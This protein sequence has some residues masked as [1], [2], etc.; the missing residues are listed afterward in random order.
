M[1]GTWCSNLHQRH[2]CYRP[3]RFL[4]KFK[5]NHYLHLKPPYCYVFVSHLATVGLFASL[6]RCLGSL[7]CMNLWPSGKCFLTKGSI[8]TLLYNFNKQWCIHVSFKDDNLG[9]TL[10]AYASPNVDFYRMFSSKSKAVIHSY[11]LCNSH[12]LAYITSTIME[13]S[14]YPS[15]D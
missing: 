15:N 3:N 14:T 7:S 6:D 1:L 5:S 2:I 9:W 10:Q 12:L 13:A 8:Y 4:M 11:A